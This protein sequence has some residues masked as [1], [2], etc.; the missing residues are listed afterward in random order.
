M[1]LNNKQQQFCIYFPSN[2]FYKEVQDKWNP[3]VDKMRLPYQ[4][5]TDFMNAQIQSVEFP[6]VNMDLII[7]QREQYEYAQ[8]NGKELENLIDKNLTITFKLT[9]S[10]ISYW[11][12]FNQIDLYMHYKRGDEERKPIWM[13]PIQMSF[14]TDAGFE[15]TKFTFHQITPINLTQLKMSYA[16]TVASYNT[17]SWTLHYNAFDID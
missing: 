15:L 11:I 14:L 13:E 3:I 6:G 10:Y 16:A 4:D 5:V 1:V 8:P 7:Q 12:L 9:E 17:F 2:F